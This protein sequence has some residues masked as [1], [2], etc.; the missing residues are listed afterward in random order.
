MPGATVMHLP[1]DPAAAA[2]VLRALPDA[3]RRAAAADR[4]LVLLPAGLVAHPSAVA[5]LVESP[6]PRTQLVVGAADPADSGLAVVVAAG[7]VAGARAPGAAAADGEALAPGAWRV[8]PGDAEVVAAAL[9]RARVELPEPV[10]AGA[11]ADLAALAVVRSGALVAAL[12]PEPLVLVRP[13]DVGEG[14]ARVA[15]RDEHAV[16]LRRSSR[17][18]DGFYSTFVVRPMSRRVTAVALR[19]GLTPNTVTVLS[20]LL[21]FVAA[22]CFAVGSY[23]GRAGRRSSRPAAAAGWAARRRSR[24]AAPNV[25]L[26]TSLNWRTE[27]KPEAKATWVSGRQVWSI[28]RRAKWA[29]R[30]RATDSGVYVAK[31]GGG[32]VNTATGD[33]VFGMT[34]AYLIENG[35]ITAPLREG[36]LIGNGPQVLLDIDLLGND[37]AMGNPGTCGKDGQGVPVGD[38]QPTL[39]VKSMTIGGTAA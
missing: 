31:L 1:D 22:G 32:S 10:G 21:G 2:D 8:V 29:R 15:A 37:F 6:S 25:A 20:L 28:S 16:R 27:R 9:E 19:V 39:R 5:D 7:V 24:G 11:A 30:V 26:S 13:V 12:R 23:G 33:F 35:E 4:A 14:E 17:A 34:E 36:N 3:L 38:G 18:D